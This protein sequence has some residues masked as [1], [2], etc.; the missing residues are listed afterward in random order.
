MCYGS[1]SA[2]VKKVIDRS[3]GTSLAF[4]LPISTPIPKVHWITQG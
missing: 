3:I 1:Y 4:F 2:N